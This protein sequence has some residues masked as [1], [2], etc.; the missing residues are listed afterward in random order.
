MSALGKF[1]RAITAVS[2][3]RRLILGA[4]LLAVALPLALPLHRG[5]GSYP[6]A[7]VL[8]CVAAIG[9]FVWTLPPALTITAGVVLSPLA[10]NWRLLGV[11]GSASPDRLLLVAG[12]SVVLCRGPGARALPRLRIRPTHAVLGLLLVYAVISAAASKTLLHHVGFFRLFDAFG[13]L[14]FLIFLVAPIV[15]HD[16][17]TR[18]VLLAGV[19][20]LGAY[21]GLTAIFEAA[22]LSSLVFPH[23]IVTST[24]TDRTGRAYGAFLEPVSNGVG[25]FY[26]GVAAVVA[27]VTWRRRSARTFAALA[28]TVCAAGVFFTLE[29]SVWLGAGIALVVVVGAAV[30]RLK[31][32]APRVASTAALIVAAAAVTGTALLFV[33]GLAHKAHHRAT[34][35][36]TVWDRQNLATAAENM[37]EAR[38]LL[39]FG[40]SRFEQSSLEY[41][42][43]NANYPLDPHLA[44]DPG[45]QGTF[46]VHNEFLDYAV[47]LGL[48]G[49]A[50]WLLGLALALGGALRAHGPPDL[51]H[52]RFGLLPVAVFYIVIENA[53]PPALFPNLVLWLWLGVVWAGYRAPGISPAARA[54]QDP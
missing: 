24:A 14:P 28:A 21:L 52:W 1:P 5:A 32:W 35:Q 2:G 51:E 17:R 19:V 3:G 8:V 13:V 23:Y 15:F 27:F 49:T 6:V 40:W 33:P 43:Q 54:V 47:T 9:Y 7:A 48:V 50:V 42:R 18:S 22:K 53:V 30:P 29:R 44:F 12:I 4:A 10:S 41:F 38:P 25:L 37:I 36:A 31:R 39:G 20:G 34:D 45:S 16:T 26:C 11:P 46:S